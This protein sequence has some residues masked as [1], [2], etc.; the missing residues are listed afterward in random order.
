[1]HYVS[2]PNDQ[3]SG[4]PGRSIRAAAQR[5]MGR[6]DELA[7]C[8]DDPHRLT[9]TFCS[10]AMRQAH[11]RISAWMHELSMTTTQD[12]LGNLFGRFESGL[13]GSAA[14][15]QDCAHVHHRLPP[16]HRD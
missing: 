15:P 10:E 6:C 8:S 13:P 14:S 4:E 3:L 2:E 12:S 1:M 5:V 11:E 16:G 9:R 7:T